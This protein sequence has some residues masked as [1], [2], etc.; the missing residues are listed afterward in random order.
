[1]SY[2]IAYR[3]DVGVFPAVAP[4]ILTRLTSSEKASSITTLPI[5]R[6]ERFHIKRLRL[7]RGL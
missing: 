3:F 6:F 1:M 7:V 2:M 4:S 5:D